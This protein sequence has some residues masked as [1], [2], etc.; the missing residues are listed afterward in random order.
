M[1]EHREFSVFVFSKQI[2]TSCFSIIKDCIDETMMLNG[3]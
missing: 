1:N 2:E 3:K